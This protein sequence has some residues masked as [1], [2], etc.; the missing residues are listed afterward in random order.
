[1]S[2]ARI[3]P[4]G[5]DPR[6]RVTSTPC[7]RASRR[8]FGE[9]LSSDGE[10]GVG[11]LTPALA[12][13]PPAATVSV[14][15]P[16]CAGAV[17]IGSASPGASSQAIVWPTGI[18]APS[19]AETAERMP[20]PGDSTSTTALSVST[21]SIG[22][23]LATC[24]PSRLRQ[25]TTL[26]VSCAISR[27]GITTL[28]AIEK[29]LRESAALA[30]SDSFR[31][32]AGFH[33]FDHALARRS[34]ALARGGQRSVHREVV[35]ACHQQ[36]FGREARDHFVAGRR[37]HDFFLDARRAPAVGGGPEGLQR[38]HHAR[39][40]FVRVLQRD[41]AA[42]HR[43]L[44]NRQAH[45][46]PKLQCEC[47]LLTRDS[48]LL[49]CRPY[50]GHLRGG[51]ARPD[52]FDRRIQV[53]PAALVSIHHGMRSVSDGEAAVVTGAIAHVGMQNVVVDRIA[54]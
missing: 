27:A 17:A 47:P 2:S 41:Q 8:A 19:W 20:S 34:F 44:P 48:K 54:G 37:D 33:H 46:V 40:Q 39:L 22:S 3:S 31:L 13:A 11:L 7:S 52:Q 21:S 18:T 45:S 15:R 36:F 38:K 42:D 24:S 43:L 49:S 9:I 23:P 53:F 35:C 5:P 25:E 16:V 28:T 50:R 26:P 32:R 1:M 14:R 6:S 10:T 12:T 51:P 29:N 4:P 30:H